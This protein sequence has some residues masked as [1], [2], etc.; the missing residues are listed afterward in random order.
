MKKKIHNQY[1]Y[2]LQEE[3]KIKSEL[4]VILYISRKKQLSWRGWKMR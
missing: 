4:E 1:E 3:E 2:N